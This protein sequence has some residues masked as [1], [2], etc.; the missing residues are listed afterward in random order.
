MK[1][2]LFI[3]MSL[4]TVNLTI[5]QEEKPILKN[6]FNLKNATFFKQIVN[7]NTSGST[8]LDLTLEYE[9]RI[10]TEISYGASINYY[11]SKRFLTSD[12]FNG[13]ITNQDTNRNSAFGFSLNVKYD[14]S[15]LIGL[16]TEKIDLFTGTSL[17]VSNSEYLIYST[18]QSGND[19]TTKT[20]T[21]SG[22]NYFIGTSLGARYWFTKNIG[23][24]A[25]LDRSFYKEN[26]NLTKL[27]LGVNFK[28]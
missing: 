16:N 13:V 5:A 15:K 20:T 21:L 14:W 6:Q 9:R 22:N 11:Q 2:L 4:L 25:E 23:I 27:N 12:T 8:A 1:K 28:F 26:E 17:G 18:T 24:S 7:G 10:N 3:T 19:I